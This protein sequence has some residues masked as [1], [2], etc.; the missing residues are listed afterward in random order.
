MSFD[1]AQKH[2]EEEEEKEEE[3]ETFPLRQTPIKNRQVR[4]SLLRYA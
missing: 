2:A 3:E 4:K 1:P